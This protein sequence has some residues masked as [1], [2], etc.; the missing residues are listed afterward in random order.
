MLIMYLDSYIN[1]LGKS[2][3]RNLKFVQLVVVIFFDFVKFLTTWHVNQHMPN[4][5]DATHRR[6]VELTAQ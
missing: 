1:E 4:D 6:V 2:S 5:D 3:Q